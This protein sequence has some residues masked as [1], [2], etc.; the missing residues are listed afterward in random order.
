MLNEDKHYWL[1]INKVNTSDST[2]AGDILASAFTCA[3]I[4]ERDILWAFSFWSWSSNGFIKDKKEWNRKNSKK[5]FIEENA[6]YNYNLIKYE[7]L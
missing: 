7:S 3:F 1:D 6:S 5:K 2:G 4:K